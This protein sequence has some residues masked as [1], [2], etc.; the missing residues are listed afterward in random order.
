MVLEAANINE[1]A[2]CG[3]LII[4]G[5]VVCCACEREEAGRPDYWRCTKCGKTFT[6]RE[7]NSFEITN[8]CYMCN[9]PLKKM[10]I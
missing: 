6:N 1:C 4:D 3:I 9:N 2:V 5:G 7:L 10:H 8:E